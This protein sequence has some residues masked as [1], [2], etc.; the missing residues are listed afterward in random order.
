MK[1]AVVILLLAGLAGCGAYSW[2]KEGAGEAAFKADSTACEQQAQAGGFNDCMT[3][4]G[5]TLRNY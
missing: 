3:G 2:R 1:R 5:W 4:R